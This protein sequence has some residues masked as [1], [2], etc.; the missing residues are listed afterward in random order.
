MIVGQHLKVQLGS[1]NPKVNEYQFNN[2]PCP[3]FPDRPDPTDESL[4]V[5]VEELIDS[6]VAAIAEA[7]NERLE[8]G[9]FAPCCEWGDQSTRAKA[10][11][12]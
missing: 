8:E 12:C 4:T 3:V 6:D 10:R 7:L 11:I 2:L 1:T 9:P 5:R